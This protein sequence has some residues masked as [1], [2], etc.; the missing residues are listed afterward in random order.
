MRFSYTPIVWNKQM[1]RTHQPCV[2]TTEQSCEESMCQQQ[3]S[4]KGPSG[5]MHQPQ[6]G[7]H[8]AGSGGLCDQ[9][10]WAVGLGGPCGQF[11]GAL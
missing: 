9:E 5:K 1:L 11:S 3:E 2:V 7:L 4:W 10:R 8:T 6:K